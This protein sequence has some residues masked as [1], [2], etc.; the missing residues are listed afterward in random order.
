M[1]GFLRSFGYAFKGIG[2]A[3]KQRNFKI[4]LLCAILVL[5]FRVLLFR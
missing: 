4:Q 3:F 1:N 5:A 2:F